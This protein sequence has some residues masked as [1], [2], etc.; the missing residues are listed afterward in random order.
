M[1]N[2]LAYY[3]VIRFTVKVPAWRHD[4]RFDGTLLDDN[5]RDYT[6]HNVM[7]SI[8]SFYCFRKCHYAESNFAEYSYAEYC[9]AECHYSV[10]ITLSIITLVIV[11]LSII[12]QSV[13]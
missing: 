9:Y 3:A 6:Q 7:L 12:K 13:M 10:M 1:K 5:Q 11:M 8:E 4:T 2:A